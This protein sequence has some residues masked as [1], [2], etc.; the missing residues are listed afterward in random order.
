[1]DEYSS[2]ANKTGKGKN[3]AAVLLT[4]GAIAAAGSA[5]AASR[6]H[7]RARPH[8]DAPGRTRRRDFGDYDVVGKTV[9][10]N[11]RRSELFAFWRD[12][13]N[14]P[15][16]MENI[17]DVQLTGNNGRAVWTIKAPAGQSVEVETEIVQERENELIAWRSVKGSD[18]DAEGRVK[19]RDAPGDRGTWVEAIIAYKPPGGSVGKMIAKLFAKEPEIQARRD[20]KRLKMFMETGEIADG[21]HYAEKE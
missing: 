8:D 1:M 16:F 3:A 19:F 20:L 5:Y 2:E 4:V 21:R 9:T 6:R 12:F 10:I 14:L 18:I 15:K 11:R 7:G 13:Q 17:E